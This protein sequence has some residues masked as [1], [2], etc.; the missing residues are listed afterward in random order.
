MCWYK[1]QHSWTKKAQLLAEKELELDANGKSTKNLYNNFKINLKILRYKY[2]KPEWI[3]V[4]S[5]TYNKFF[6]R[7]RGIVERKLKNGS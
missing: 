1:S 2:K 3:R 5:S 6:W 7:S 4:K